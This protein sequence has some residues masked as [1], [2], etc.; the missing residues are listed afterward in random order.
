M[1]LIPAAAHLSTYCLM[2]CQSGEEVWNQKGHHNCQQSQRLHS[3]AKALFVWES[4][5]PLTGDVSNEPA[6][7]A[8]SDSQARKLSVL[9]RTNPSDRAHGSSTQP[10]EISYSPQQGTTATVREKGQQAA[11][12][13]YF[14]RT[15]STNRGPWKRRPGSPCRFYEPQPST[16]IPQHNF[17]SFRDP[18]PTPYV[19]I[20]APCRC[21]CTCTCTCSSW[22]A[23]PAGP[24]LLASLHI[25]YTCKCLEMAW[26]VYNIDSTVQYCMKVGRED[27]MTTNWQRRNSRPLSSPVGAQARSTPVTLKDLCIGY[28]KRPVAW[29]HPTGCR[30]ILYQ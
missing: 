29:R 2:L 21:T 19:S 17:A 26:R 11:R 13:L 9:Q 14:R 27:G 22:A 20:S 1:L 23:A 3:H 4:R 5:I 8:E 12:R 6:A 18:A 10:P 7:F 16:E 28:P 15:I 30:I 25:T 24:R